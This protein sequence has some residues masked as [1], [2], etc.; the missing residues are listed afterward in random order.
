MSK[1]DND[2][3]GVF[4]LVDLR[5]TLQAH[6]FLMK[7]SPDALKALAGVAL[8]YGLGEYFARFLVQQKLN[9]IV[10]GQ[11]KRVGGGDDGE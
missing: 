6:A 9:V 5:N 11:V 4:R 3:I 10:E 1:Y 2:M 7:D 8:A